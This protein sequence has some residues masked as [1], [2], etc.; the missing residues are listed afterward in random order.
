MFN[1]PDG[2]TVALE[3][4]LEGKQYS[5]LARDNMFGGCNSCQDYCHNHCSGDCG[6]PQKGWIA[7]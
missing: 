3:Q 2:I 6:G 7:P 5:D 4:Q 1:L